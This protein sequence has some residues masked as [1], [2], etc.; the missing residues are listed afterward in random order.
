MFISDNDEMP[1]HSWKFNHTVQF[2]LV[3]K[4]M[5]VHCIIVHEQRKLPSP[6]KMNEL[7]NGFFVILKNIMQNRSA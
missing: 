3:R 6:H 5:R 2:F 7:Y 4:C 1:G